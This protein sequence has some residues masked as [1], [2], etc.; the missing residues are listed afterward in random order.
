M[1]MKQSLSLV[2]FEPENPKI[3][4]F[5]ISEIRLILYSAPRKQLKFKLYMHGEIK[6]ISRNTQ[7]TGTTDAAPSV[8]APWLAWPPILLVYITSHVLC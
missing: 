6:Q 2:K 7:Q 1:L 3:I 4:N 5:I 8:P